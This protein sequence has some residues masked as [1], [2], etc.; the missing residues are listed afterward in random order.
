MSVRL[1]KVSFAYG[2]TPV[3][4]DVTW[5][6]PDSG[7]A[8]LWGPSGCGKTTLL[9][10][11]A[12]LERPDSGRIQAPGRVSM[13]FQE[14]RLLPWLTA[15]QNV[16]VVGTEEDTA[17]RWMLSLGLTEGELQSLPDALSGGQQ[18]RV[19]LARA[20]AAD[21]DYLLLDEPFNG[22]D[23]DTW[24]AAI[25]WIAEYAAHR[26]VVLV[27]HVRQQA[28]ALHAALIPLAGVPVSGVLCPAENL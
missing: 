6:L 1:E 5:Q 8:C 18:R 4:R 22:L 3:C 19:A 14:D 13:V 7:V 26:P 25:P 11:L 10:L 27:T 24:R 21:S 2:D 23:E 12:G 9:R 28:E 17:R 20:L 15:L 16:T